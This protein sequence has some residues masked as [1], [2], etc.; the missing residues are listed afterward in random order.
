VMSAIEAVVI[1]LAG[2]A[3]D[4]EEIARRVALGLVSA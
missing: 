2:R 4:D 1:A 3:G